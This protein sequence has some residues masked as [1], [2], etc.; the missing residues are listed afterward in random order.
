[1]SEFAHIADELLVKNDLVRASSHQDGLSVS[2]PKALDFGFNLNNAPNES[3]DSDGV[4][5]SIQSKFYLDK[6]GPL[7]HSHFKHSVRAQQ[8]SAELIAEELDVVGVKIFSKVEPN[9]E[10]FVIQTILAKGSVDMTQG[11]FR[12]GRPIVY[13]PEEQL[14]PRIYIYIYIYIEDLEE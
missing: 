13:F 9:E 6:D 4:G 12:F 2:L 1:M 14:L 11:D 8:Y 3:M 7:I 5:M 10:R